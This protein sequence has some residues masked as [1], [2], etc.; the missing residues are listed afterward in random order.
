MRL[1]L[2]CAAII[3]AGLIAGTAFATQ[4]GYQWSSAKNLTI[5]DTTTH[6]QWTDALAKAATDW[7]VSPYVNITVERVDICPQKAKICVRDF[8]NENGPF[9]A[10]ALIWV[11]NSDHIYKAWIMLNSYNIDWTSP[12][13]VFDRTLCHEVGHVLGLGYNPNDTVSCMGNGIP[14]VPS[15]LDFADLE[16][17]Y[18]H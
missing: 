15:A 3:A 5:Y 11:R 12:Q 2:A 7:S 13:Y 8:N 1:L 9:Y 16:A 18:G 17:M 10:Y 4:A 14:G 6:Q